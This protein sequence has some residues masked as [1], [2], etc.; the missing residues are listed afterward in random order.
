MSV[1]F[2]S[3]VMYAALKTDGTEPVD[4]ERLNRST[5]NGAR[6]STLSLLLNFV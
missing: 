1:F 3:G 2:D 6:R 5:R 4:R